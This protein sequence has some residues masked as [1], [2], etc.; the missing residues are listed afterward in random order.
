LFY[1]INVVTLHL[2]PLR[3][4]K[5]DIEPLARFF[6]ERL[7]P[8]YGGRRPEFDEEAMS[9]LSGY[10]WPGNVRELENVMESILAL[11]NSERVTVDDLPQR[12]KRAPSGAS[13]GE[14]VLDQNISF[15]EAERAFETDIIVKALERSSYVQTKAAELL[16]ISRR[17]L[18]YKMDKLGISDRPADKPSDS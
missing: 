14:N 8:L 16:G 6:V 9:I 3:E 4:R 1:R 11:S 7:S 15:E 12:I 5:E 2:P 10:S 17:I 13:L 18:K